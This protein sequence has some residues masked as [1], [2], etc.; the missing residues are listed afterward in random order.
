[1]MLEYCA[2]GAIDSIMVELGKPLTE[3]QIAYVT[4]GV[5]CA[6][7]FLHDNNVIHRDLKA[8]NI[9]LTSDGVVKLGIKNRTN[10][11]V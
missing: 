3:Q 1:M 8:G 5:S 11:K 7:E 9:L 10:K 4:H 2:G 6:L